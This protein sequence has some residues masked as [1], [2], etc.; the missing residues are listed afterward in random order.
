MFKALEW[1]IKAAGEGMYPSERFDGGWRGPRDDGRE[2]LGGSLLS[3]VGAVVAMKGDWIEI[4]QTFGF[5]QWNSIMRP[6]CC[7]DTSRSRLY[8]LSQV[9]VG[10]WDGGQT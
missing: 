9:A 6:C 4:S 7:R 8:E 2:A 10:E 5:L 3:Y 1:S